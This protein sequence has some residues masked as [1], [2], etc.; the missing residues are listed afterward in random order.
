MNG[1]LKRAMDVV[2]ALLGL[3]VSAP[4]M[5]LVALLIRLDSPGKVIFSQPRLGLNGRLFLMH[6]FRKFPD[7]WGTKGAAVTVASDA[8]MT[9]LGR[10][11]E[12]TKLDELPQ[13]WNILIGEMSFVGPRPETERFKDLFTGEF[14]RV[15]DYLPGIFGPN[16]VAFRNESHLYPPDQDP[17]VFYREQLFPQKARNDLD[18]FSRATVLSDAHWIVRGL[19]CSIVG[20]IDWNKLGRRAGKAF[21][22]DLVIL[23]LAW[24]G[25]NILR[26]DGLP[27]R[28]LWDVYVMGI[29]LIPLVVLP[30]L[31]LGGNYRG[32]VRHF[33]AT[34]AIRLA[35]SVFV[36]WTIA[37]LLVLVGGER[38]ASIGVGMIA[39]MLTLMQMG[40]ARVFYRERFRRANNLK[41]EAEARRAHGGDPRSVVALYG[42]GHRGLA[43]AS[44][45]NHG[46]PD[47]RVAGFLDDNDRDLVGRHIAGYPILGSERD[48]DTVHAVHRI[49]QL[50]TTF[51]PN[52]FKYERLRDW[53]RQNEVRLVVLPVTEPF[54]SLN[55][56]G[57]G[58]SSFA[59][60]REAAAY[61]QRPPERLQ[62]A[63]S[64]QRG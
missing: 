23:E 21:V 49:D 39:V 33:A 64:P 59:A 28:H 61:R 57:D 13:L 56:T 47:A 38:N 40:A 20:A 22:A 48:L 41:R 58:D 6:K 51:E 12:R 37:Y 29:W 17:E 10:V 3:I 43:V 5:L 62:P 52:R 36:G 7:N 26:F 11:L 8:R 2:L 35:V 16:Q 9:R 34:D 30:V 53:C 18:Y 32:M 4:L 1:S 24:L 46:F 42:A 15:H 31:I 14:A 19:W 60:D 44:L 55:M 27:T 45:L 25:A 63:T 50:W 54:L